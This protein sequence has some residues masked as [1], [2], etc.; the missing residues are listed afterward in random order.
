MMPR[1]KA[2]AAP[3]C[4]IPLVWAVTNHGDVKRCQ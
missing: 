2:L 1:G 3:A 4:T